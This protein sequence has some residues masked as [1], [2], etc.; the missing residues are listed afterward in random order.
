MQRTLIIGASGQV[1]TALVG[2]LGARAIPLTR[3]ELDITDLS[4][5]EAAV[6]QHPASAVINCA[7]FTAVD[8]AESE[9]EL[10]DLINHRAVAEMARVTASLDIPFI[11]YSTDYVFDGSARAPYLESDEPAPKSVY[12][13]T[14]LRGELAAAAANPATLIIR[15]SWI[16]SR[17]HDNFVSTMLRLASGSGAKVVD[18][19]WGRPTSA[20]DLAT[21]TVR[22]VDRGLQGVLHMTNGGVPTTWFRLA[23]K[24]A[25]LAGLDESKLEPCTTSDFPRPAPRP[26]WSV[27]ASA[28]HGEISPLPDWEEALEPIVRDQMR[29]LGPAAPDSV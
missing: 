21:G 9:A 4:S 10:A 3:S 19:Q 18:D 29:R 27:L 1:G 25:E 15:T 11:T 23:R 14:K 24:A 22:A 13:E 26:A 20:D 8:L 28:R 7:A 17:T 2:Q 6:Q 16:V 12:G 5:I